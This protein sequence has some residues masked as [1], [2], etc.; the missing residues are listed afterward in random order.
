MSFLTN[1]VNGMKSLAWGNPTQSESS[2]A[3]QSQPKKTPAEVFKENLSAF[4]AM[5]VS[6][7]ECIANCCKSVREVLQESDCDLSEASQQTITLHL[8][9]FNEAVDDESRYLFLGEQSKLKT[10][11]KKSFGEVVQEKW[12][13]KVAQSFFCWCGLF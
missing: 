11:F 8:E 4:A 1:I 2:L 13:A 3:A 10:E 9:D 6:L 12:A 5:Q 7:E